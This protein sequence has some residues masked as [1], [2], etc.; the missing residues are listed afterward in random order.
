MQLF[1]RWN[2]FDAPEVCTLCGVSRSYA[3]T[4]KF[5]RRSIHRA[6]TKEQRARREPAR[7]ESY[8]AEADV[9][10]RGAERR[11]SSPRVCTDAPLERCVDGSRYLLCEKLCSANTW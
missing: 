9:V 11:C 7:Q 4:V 6:A 8:I 5:L 10:G 2:R 3:A 1:S